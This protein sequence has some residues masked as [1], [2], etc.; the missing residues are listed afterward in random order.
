MRKVLTAA[1]AAAFLLCGA[2]GASAVPITIFG[3]DFDG[4]ATIGS[5][6]GIAY[7][8]SDSGTATE[9]VQSLPGGLGFSG[10]F[11]RNDSAGG[12]TS[13]GLTGLGAHT[14][15]S[16]DFLLAILDS[17]DGFNCCGPDRMHF[18]IDGVDVF[19][20]IFATAG[21]GGQTFV[22]DSSGHYGFNAGWMDQVAALNF[23]VAHA[24][25]TLVLDWYVSGGWQAGDDESWG[26]DNLNISMEAIETEP[27]PVPEPGTLMLLGLPLA[28]LAVRRLRRL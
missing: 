25:S 22:P 9:S 13:L 27:A 17:W 10:A 1:F 4:P 8:V 2:I 6:V 21:G 5:G 12:W 11:L 16:V 26:I 14:S 28:G 23:T 7:F 15:V 20:E 19:D 3:T 24:A 18:R